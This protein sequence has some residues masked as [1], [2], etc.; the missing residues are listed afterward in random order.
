LS[1]ILNWQERHNLL[2]VANSFGDPASGTREP[3]VRDL[4]DWDRY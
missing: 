2:A 1:D 3:R 4:A